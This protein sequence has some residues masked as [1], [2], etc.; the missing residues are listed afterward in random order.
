MAK[1]TNNQGFVYDA[2]DLLRFTWDKRWILIIVS[3]VAFIVSII[4]SITNHSPF[5]VNGNYV[6]CCISFSIKKPC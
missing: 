3:I 4:V 6:P 5:P 2:F 1:N